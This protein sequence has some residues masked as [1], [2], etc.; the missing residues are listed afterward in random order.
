MYFKNAWIFVW[1]IILVKLY[2]GG[3]ACFSS[4]SMSNRTQQHLD[5]EEQ[6]TYTVQNIC[7][8]VPRYRQRDATTHLDWEEQITI[9][10][11]C[12][13][14]AAPRQRDATTP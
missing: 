10:Y 6:T 2:E 13:S 11:I 7:S 9:G 12:S 5:W 14:V 1:I 8:S 3:G 4:G